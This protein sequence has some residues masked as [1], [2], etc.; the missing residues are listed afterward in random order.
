MTPS[1]SSSSSSSTFL[2]ERFFFSD[3]AVADAGVALGIADFF[4]DAFGVLGVAAFFLV[5]AVAV[6]AGDAER[7]RVDPEAGIFGFI[8][9]KQA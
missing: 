2:V 9:Q 6:A 7:F 3:V 4:V 5:E 1:S 8:F